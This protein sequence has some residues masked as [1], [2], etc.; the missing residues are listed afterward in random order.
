MLRRA[1]LTGYELESRWW[2]DA[3]VE[4]VWECLC[5]PEHWTSWWEYVERVEQVER[6]EENGIGSVRRYV[7]K[8]R[9]PYRLILDMRVTR[10]DPGRLLEVAVS[11]DLE[12]CGRC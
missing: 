5:H 6:G 7:W 12:G 4:R 8:T 2:L 3:P 9:L 10:V 1:P 11:G